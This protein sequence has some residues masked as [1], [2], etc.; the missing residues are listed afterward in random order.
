MTSKDIM[1]SKEPTVHS[2]RCTIGKAWRRLFRDT[3]MHVVH[4]QNTT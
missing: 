4:V 1:D 2:N 3:V